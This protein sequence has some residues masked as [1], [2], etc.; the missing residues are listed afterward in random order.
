MPM[1]RI[2]FIIMCDSIINI[3]CFI[4]TWTNQILFLLIAY[5]YIHLPAGLFRVQS[6]VFWQ[7]LLKLSINMSTLISIL[8]RRVSTM[9]RN[10]KGWLIVLGNWGSSTGLDIFMLFR[11]CFVPDWFLLLLWVFLLRNFSRQKSWR[12]DSSLWFKDIWLIFMLGELRG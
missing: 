8:G 6:L 4:S 11:G 1:M 10:L 2:N 7:L 12:R 9:I 5:T 3:G